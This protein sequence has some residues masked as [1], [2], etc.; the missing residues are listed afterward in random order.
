MLG[1]FALVGG[2]ID[3]LA[4]MGVEAILVDWEDIGCVFPA[5]AMPGAQ[6]LI[7]LY[8]HRFISGNGPGFSHP[9]RVGYHSSCS[10]LIARRKAVS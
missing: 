10:E 2:H 7:D 9:G 3:F 5:A 1:G 4:A 6:R 8:T